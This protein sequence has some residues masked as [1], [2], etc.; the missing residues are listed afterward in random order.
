MIPTIV[1]D[2]EV[3]GRTLNKELRKCVR[4]VTNNIL[5]ICVFESV[6]LQKTNYAI[7]TFVI[8]LANISIRHYLIYDLL[9]F[10]YIVRGLWYLV[11]G[12]VSTNI[13]WANGLNLLIIITKCIQMS[14][15]AIMWLFSWDI[16][17]QEIYWYKQPKK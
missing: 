7:P 4:N 6:Y 13:L 1:F 16:Y 9:A 2:I 17:R 8:P 12:I 3:F 11:S 14:H 5:N 10:N 15:F